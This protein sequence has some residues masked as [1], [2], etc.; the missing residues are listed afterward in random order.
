RGGAGTLPEAPGERGNAA[1]RLNGGWLTPTE[2]ARL[3]SFHQAAHQAHDASMHHH[4]AQVP[5]AQSA[6]RSIGIAV[7]VRMRENSQSAS[8]EVRHAVRSP[9]RAGQTRPVE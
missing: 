2:A 9:T 7:D 6:T 3:A 8:P 1:H 5:R 4:P